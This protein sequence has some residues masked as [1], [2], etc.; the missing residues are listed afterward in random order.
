MKKIIHFKMANVIKLGSQE[1]MPLFRKPF[2]N[3]ILLCNLKQSLE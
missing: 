3:L 1:N 2:K